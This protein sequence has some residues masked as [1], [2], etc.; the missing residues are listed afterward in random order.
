LKFKALGVLILTAWAVTASAQYPNNYTLYITTGPDAAGTGVLISESLSGTA[1]PPLPN[2]PGAYHRGDLGIKMGG[3]YTA[4][5]VNGQNVCT[6]CNVNAQYTW[7]LPWDISTDC[8]QNYQ[9]DLPCEVDTSP[10]NVFC[11]F[12]G[13]FWTASSGG[14]DPGLIYEDAITMSKTSSFTPPDVYHLSNWCSSATTPPDATPLLTH[15]P[16]SSPFWK[17]ATV[18]ERDKTAPRGTKWS[19]ALITPATVPYPAGTLHYNCTW[20]DGGY[21]GLPWP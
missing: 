3:N 21:K 14:Q 18:C 15:Q 12:I 9:F 8:F 2:M 16:F 11:S 20:Y 19:C 17:S 7:D 1:L 6:T 13:I 5:T 10:V 4:L